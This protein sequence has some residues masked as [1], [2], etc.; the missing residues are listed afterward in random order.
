VTINKIVKRL[1]KNYIKF[2]LSG[3]K[4]K[5]AACLD[6]LDFIRQNGYENISGKLIKKEKVLH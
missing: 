4:A 6:M 3:E 1:S 2:M 5:S